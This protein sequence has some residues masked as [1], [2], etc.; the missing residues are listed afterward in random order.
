MSAIPAASVGVKDMA[1]S[2]LRITIEFE[3]R[4]AKDAF[5]LFGARGTQVA[6]A[7]LRDGSF[8]E[9]SATTKPK[10]GDACLLAVQWCKEPQFWEW[11]NGE[12]TGGFH[13]CVNGVD[14]A[15]AFICMVCGVESRKDID[16]S[17]AALNFW[18]QNICKP[19][20]QYLIDR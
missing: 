18:H 19:F 12:Q 8:L 13:T 2:S 14:S 11:A 5:A 4:Y 1:D 7:A 3:P 10:I 16:T 6:I 9:Q 20:Q 15:K 17:P